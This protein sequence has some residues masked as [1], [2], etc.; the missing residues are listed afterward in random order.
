MRGDKHFRERRSAAEQLDDVIVE[1]GVSG[2]IPFH[3]RPE[4]RA[5]ATF[6][7]YWPLRVR[8]PFK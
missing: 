6:E 5:A 8:P 7:A 3:E 4:L 2:A 1:P